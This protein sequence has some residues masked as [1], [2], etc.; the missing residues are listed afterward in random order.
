MRSRCLFTAIIAERSKL[1]IVKGLRP[2]GN[3]LRTAKLRYVSLSKSSP[4]CFA[5]LKRFHIRSSGKQI[6]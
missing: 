3:I 4:T 1:H 2:N 6:R 5:P